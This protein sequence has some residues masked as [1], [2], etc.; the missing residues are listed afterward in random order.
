MTVLVLVDT[1]LVRLGV[2]SPACI[3]QLMM[4]GKRLEVG[5]EITTAF[6]YTRYWAIWS[7]DISVSSMSGSQNSLI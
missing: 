1:G 3:Y 7:W 5:K 4:P 2:H 6:A